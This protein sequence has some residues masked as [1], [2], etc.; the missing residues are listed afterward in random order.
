VEGRKERL[1]GRGREKLA[2]A[3]GKRRSDEGKGLSGAVELVGYW[4]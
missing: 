3:R 4:A 2:A 1:G